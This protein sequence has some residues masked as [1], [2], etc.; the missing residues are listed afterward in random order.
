MT[1]YRYLDIKKNIWSYFSI[2]KIFEKVTAWDV[3][4][5]L[6]KLAA[7]VGILAEEKEE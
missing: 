5:A 6:Q 2:K 3:G 1:F 7:I 4:R